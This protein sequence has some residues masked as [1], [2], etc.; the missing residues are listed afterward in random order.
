[1]TQWQVWLA[2]IFVAV[3]AT[4]ASASESGCPHEHKWKKAEEKDHDTLKDINPD[5]SSAKCDLS[6]LWGNQRGMQL[7]LHQGVH[8]GQLVGKIT[9]YSSDIFGVYP[10]HGSYLKDS[11]MVS[12]SAAWEND[13]KGNAKSIT[14]WTG[15][16][17][18]DTLQFSYTTVSHTPAKYAAY[19]Q[20]TD[21]HDVFVRQ[22]SNSEK[23]KDTQ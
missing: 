17:M 14:S 13:V 20:Y 19:L 1:M 12:F 8:S 5:V 10:V 9:V 15:Q 4:A 11:C 3:L 18:E 6:G 23:E 21:G 7:R 2:L 22:G 16:M